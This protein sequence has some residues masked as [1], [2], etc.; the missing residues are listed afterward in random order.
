MKLFLWQYAEDKPPLVS[1][2]DYSHVNIEQM[3]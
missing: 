1:T 2:E 3:N